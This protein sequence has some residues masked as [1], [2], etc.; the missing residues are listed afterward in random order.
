VLDIPINPACAALAIVR[1][2]IAP[3]I[4]RLNALDV[5][6]YPSFAEPNLRT[7]RELYSTYNGFLQVSPE[8]CLFTF[9]WRT[10]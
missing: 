3:K 8:K 6:F 1:T 9:I 2:A 10:G 5:I 7:P 4:L